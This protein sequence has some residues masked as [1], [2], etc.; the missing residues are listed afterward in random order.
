MASK[1]SRQ[2]GGSAGL[3]NGGNEHENSAYAYTRNV[4]I[5]LKEYGAAVVTR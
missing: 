2:H 4:T 1:A 3:E 5:L